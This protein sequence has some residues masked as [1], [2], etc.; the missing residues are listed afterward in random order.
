MRNSRLTIKSGIKQTAIAAIIILAVG[1]AAVYYVRGLLKFA[2]ESADSEANLAG[3]SGQSA[4]KTAIISGASPETIAEIAKY[5]FTEE[6]TSPVYG[7]SFKYPKDFTVTA[8][9]DG[10]GAEAVLVQNPAKNIGV[11][12]LI[13]KNDEPDSD[14]TE[15]AIRQ[16]IPDLKISD[17]QEVLIGAGRKGLAFTS[18]NE[19]FGGASREVWFIFGGYIYQISTYAETDEFLKGLFGTWRFK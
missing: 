7:F 1:G 18:D 15:A 11:Q 16:N 6:Y 8:V 17:F 12:I 13:T 5:Q 19:A 10:T 4:D 9:P 3:R 2:S 14:M